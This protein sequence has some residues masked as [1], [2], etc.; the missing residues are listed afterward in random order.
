MAQFLSRL[1]RLS[2]RRRRVILTIWVLAIVGLAVGARAWS[3]PTVDSF[4]IPGTESQRAMDLLDERLPAA[5]A[6]NASARVVL[7]VPDGRSITDPAAR[8]AIDDVVAEIAREPKVARATSPFDTGAVSPDGHTALASVAYSVP[9]ADLTDTDRDLLVE[10]LDPVR[11]AGVEVAIGGSAAEAQPSAGG[12]TE[13][14][15]ILLAAFV[16]A[17]TF[18]ALV[19]AGLPLV[20]AL[21]GVAA[22]LLGIEIATGFFDLS[23]TVSTLAMMLGLAVGIDYALFIISRYRHELL[24]SRD[25]ELAIGRA[26]GT[27]GSA[28]VFAGLTVVIALAALVVVGIPFL[29]A[30]GLAAAGTVLLA[31][32]VALTLLPALLGFAG[33]KILGR[34]GFTARDEDGDDDAQPLGERWANLVIRHRGLFATGAVALLVVMAIPVLSLRLGLPNDGNKNPGSS[35]R[36]AY[37][38]LATGFGPGFNGPLLVAVDL[39]HAPDPTAA[40]ARIHDDLTS[41]GGVASVGEPSVDTTTYLATINVIPATGPSDAA[42]TD[43][44]HDIRRRADAWEADTGAEVSVTGETAVAIDVSSKL[45]GALIPYLIVIVGLA[46]VL[47]TIVFRSLLVPVKATVGYLLSIVASFGGVVAVFQW[48]WLKDLIGLDTT[49]PILSFLPI[50][51]IGILFGLAMDYEVFLVTR[52][53]EAH[54]HGADPDDAVREGFR[55]GARVVTAAAV[56]MIG[57]FAGFILGDDATIKSMGFALALGVAIDAFV[58][59]MT[60][61]PAVMSLMGEKAWT[62]PRAIDRVLPHIDIEGAQLERDIGGTAAVE[63]DDLEIELAGSSR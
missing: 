7:T 3:G 9:A 54:V 1:G 44:V 57:V 19:A 25:Q 18:G 32:L 63:A 48:G 60:L 10:S 40:A 21:V 62:L 47:L 5:G 24:S 45:Q 14:I 35:P 42:T 46:F 12:A 20:T 8:S 11:D 34:R 29:T 41:V 28:V 22:G 55:H 37:D 16:L 27:A 30:M 49:G 6:G 53:R 13:G 36:Q 50:L 23:E 38:Q 59:R 61:V 2:F 56:I 26:A 31:V 51:L 39:A 58:V 43:L 17:L 4:S 52:M 15:G 33:T